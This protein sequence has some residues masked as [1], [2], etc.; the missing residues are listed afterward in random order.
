MGQP[1]SAAAGAA[2]QTISVLGTGYLGATH[3][4]AMAEMGFSVIAVDVDA[5]KIAV[6]KAREHGHEL[7]GAV[8]ASD[9][10]FPFPDGVEAL[11][12]AGVRAV[13]QPGGSI[14]DEQVVEVCDRLGV[15]MIFSGRRHFRH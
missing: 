11:A 12:A 13:I 3:A 15:A 6:E 2:A 9:A 5:A 4:A 14:R 7:E 1:S 8:A 10:F